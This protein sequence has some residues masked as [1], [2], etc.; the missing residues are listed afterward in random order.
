MHRRAKHLLYAI[1]PAILCCLIIG[2]CTNDLKKI[3]EISAK[4]VNSP[5]DTTK[6]V[7]IIY[8]DSA[9]VKCRILAPLM[10]EYQTKDNKPYKVMPKGVKIILFDQN[11]TAHKSNGTIV[12][13]TAYY[14]EVTKIIHFRKN[15]V[16][17]ST[18]GD[19]FKSDELNWDMTNHTITSGKPVDITMA[20]G[21]VGHG[22]SMQTNE[23]FNPFTLQNQTGL[24]YI[25]KKFD[26]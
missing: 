12:A 23:K 19:I 25:D 13:D 16:A 8:S 21:N 15:V 3:Q 1:M 10:L 7:D 20:N 18:R 11:D 9:K 14:Y 2:A 6:G 22:T 5:A 4:E 17:N 24:I 26:Q